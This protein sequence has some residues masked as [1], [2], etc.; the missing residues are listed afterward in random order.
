MASVLSNCVNVF[1]YWFRYFERNLEYTQ[2]NQEQTYHLENIQITKNWILDI[3]LETWLD[4]Y[5]SFKHL[6]IYNEWAQW[7]RKH[8]KQYWRVKVSTCSFQL[9][10]AMQSLTFCLLKL[11][12]IWT[13][14]QNFVIRKQTIGRLA[15][16]TYRC[17]IFLHSHCF[18]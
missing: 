8:K 5:L 14:C 4:F 12:Y 10:L 17:L 2:R 7:W 13:W 11:V 9:F 15:M 6:N 16:L 1:I 3:H 18:S